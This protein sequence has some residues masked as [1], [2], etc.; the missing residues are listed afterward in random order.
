MVGVG[1]VERRGR[2]K[3][4]FTAFVKRRVVD[5][6]DTSMISQY[7]AYISSSGDFCAY[8]QTEHE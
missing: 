1:V 3:A 7:D 6:F 2:Q 4:R 5:M 8:G